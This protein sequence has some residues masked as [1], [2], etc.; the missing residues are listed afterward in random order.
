MELLMRFAGRVVTILSFLPERFNHVICQDGPVLTWLRPPDHPWHHG[1]WFSWK[2][3]NGLN[4][5]EEYENGESE[6]KR[7]WEIVELTSRLTSP[8]A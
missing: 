8:H 6:G 2:T 4:Y 7:S 1:L 3:V 5:W